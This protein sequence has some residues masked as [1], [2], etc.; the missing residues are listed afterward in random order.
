MPTT[1]SG[2]RGPTGNLSYY[3][4][5][6]FSVELGTVGFA[7]GTVWQASIDI[8]AW[9]GPGPLINHIFLQ[10]A[11]PS[12]NNCFHAEFI[13]NNAPWTGLYQYGPGTVGVGNEWG[14]GA[15]ATGCLDFTKIIFEII[16]YIYPATTQ[17]T[18]N[19]SVTFEPGTTQP[20]CQYGTMANPSATT[21]STITA[22]LVDIVVAF[23]GGG[24]LA[25]VAF[26]ALIGAPLIAYDCNH[27]PPQAPTFGA[28]DFIDNTGIVAPGSWGKLL[29]LFR[30]GVW[31]FYCQCIPGGSGQPPPVMPPPPPIDPVLTKPGS[32]PDQPCSNA[33]ICSTLNV[34]VRT[35]N[36]ISLNIQWN[37][38]TNGLLPVAPAT[39]NY[40][41]GTAHTQLTG[42]GSFPVSGDVGFL[43]NIVA[44]PPVFL[45]LPGNPPYEWNMGWMSISDAN[46]MLEEKRVTRDSFVWLPAAA[47]EAVE[48]AWF[49]APDVELTVHELVPGPV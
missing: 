6:T 15:S 31:H 8:T 7:P 36:S 21:Y 9:T 16:P 34:M 25:V 39:F 24:P 45:E 22:A 28:S 2:T 40:S 5:E 33:D 37:R 18:Y 46:G 12:S 11:A 30:I 35:I 44:K 27:L 4:P 29:D 14:S 32:Q 10:Q 47:A 49:L 48:Y 42:S 38:M 20:P 17:V 3:Y 43:V 19:W 1:L 13:K 26:D 23:L 41:L